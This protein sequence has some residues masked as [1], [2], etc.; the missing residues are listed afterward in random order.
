MSYKAKPDT[1]RVLDRALDYVHSVRYRVG[2]RWVFYRLLQ[3]GTFQEKKD[4]KRLTT[5]TSRARKNFAHGWE[6][7]TL[8]DDTRS[9]LL[10]ER[11]GWYTL[12]F[13]GHGFASEEAW[14][15]AVL[16][17]LNCP[18]DRWMTQP[19]YVELWFEAKA[20][21]SQFRFYADENM[22]LLP[23]GGDVSINEKWVSSLRLLA[24]W[25]SMHK[26]VY[27][28]YYGDLDNKGLLIPRS[29]ERDVRWFIRC[30][31]HLTEGKSTD[32]AKQEAQSFF[33]DFHWLRMGLNRE[34]V[35]RFSIPT[36]PDRPGSFQWEAL[37]DAGAQTLITEANSYVD[38]AAFAR[39]IQQETEIRDRI[40]ARL[41]GAV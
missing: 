4:Y 10:S 6:P 36:N 34:H 29:A 2:L 28:L 15:A 19:A 33:D 21:L 13:R 12:R 7:D 9:A 27:V 41:N 35:S 22:P 38:S 24:R 39:I 40:R 18:L 37:D 31:I 25:R 17:E 32:E 23:F 5:Y 20:M 1:E 26:P 16:K 14:M 3:D 30:A 8:T 11:E